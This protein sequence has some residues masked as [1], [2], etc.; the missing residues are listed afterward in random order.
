MPEREVRVIRSPRRAKTV[1][2]RDLGY[3][4]EVRVPAGLAPSEEESLVSGVL[5]KLKKKTSAGRISDEELLDRAW[6]LNERLLG[7]R[8]RIG[9]VRWVGNQRRRWGSCSQATGDIRITDRL[10]DVP[11]Y[12]LDAVL[13][14]ELV[15]TFV[16]GGHTEE[17][18]RFAEL[19]PRAERARGYLEA[20]QRYGPG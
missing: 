14:H 18:R 2:A 3:R 6:A 4:V 19:A 11:G 13:V 9:S 1:Q 16:P 10:K 20:L 15:H 8:A 5:E 17:F 7:G 12:V